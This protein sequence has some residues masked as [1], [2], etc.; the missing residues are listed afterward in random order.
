LAYNKIESCAEFEQERCP[1]QKEMERVY[2]IP[3]LIPLDELQQ[4]E[5]ICLACAKSQDDKGS[6]LR[7]TPSTGHQ[8]LPT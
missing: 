6:D 3:Q 2:L 4:Y 5:K 8:S 7:A 1:H